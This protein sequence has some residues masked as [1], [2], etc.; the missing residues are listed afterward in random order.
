MQPKSLLPLPPAFS[1]ALDWASPSWQS[2][3][4]FSFSPLLFRETFLVFPPMRSPL[5]LEAGMITTESP[6]PSKGI[7]EV[8][9]L[10]KLQQTGEKY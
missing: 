1:T 5:V 6:L 9:F 4:V 7:L 10:L 2:Q 3:S 8:I